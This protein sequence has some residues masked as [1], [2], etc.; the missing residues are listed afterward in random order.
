[1]SQ[2]AIV[3]ELELSL[4]RW[5]Q[6]LWSG[7]VYDADGNLTQVAKVP[8]A[9]ADLLYYEDKDGNHRYFGPQLVAIGRVQDDVLD[10]ATKAAVPSAYIEISPNDYQNIEQWRHSIYRRMDGAQRI[11]NVRYDSEIG[12]SHRV[13]RRI[14]LNMTLYCLESDQDN[15]EVDRMGNAAS[16]F[17]EALCTSGTM[18]DTEYSWRMTDVDNRLIRDPFGEAPIRSLPVIIHSRRRG[19]GPDDYIWDIKIYVEILC[20]KEA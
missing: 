8:D 15:E 10:L 4:K 17:L 9:L 3:H 20:F 6:K 2:H 7:D 16:S 18:M 12:S 13:H 11:D 14:M 5:I 1:M 19:G